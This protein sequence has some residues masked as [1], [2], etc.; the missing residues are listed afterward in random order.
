[1]HKMVQVDFKQKYEGSIMNGVFHLG[2]NMYHPYRVSS[3][4]PW[5]ESKSLHIQ[6]GH[7]VFHNHV[8]Y[9]KLD[10]EDGFYY[11]IFFMNYQSNR[12]Y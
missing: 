9:F 4:W 1:M 7:H 12:I 2:K 3:H 10:L 11:S 6:R 5:T 8:T